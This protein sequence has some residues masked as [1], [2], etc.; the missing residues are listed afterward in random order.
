MPER[1]AMRRAYSPRGCR[2]RGHHEP[3][4]APASLAPDQLLPSRRTRACAAWMSPRYQSLVSITTATAMPRSTVNWWTTGGG[5]A[6]L[7]SGSGSDMVALDCNAGATAAAARPRAC[8]RRLARWRS[9]DSG[10]NRSPRGWRDDPDIF[11][12]ERRASSRGGNGR[13]RWTPSPRAVCSRPIRTFRT[14]CRALLSLWPR[15]RCEQLG[16]RRGARRVP[17]GVVKCSAD[18]P[19]STATGRE[20]LFHFPP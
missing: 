18:F 13:R 8:V 16:A 2:E 19:S 6:P 12:S 7:G 10:E 14:S 9:D 5:A 1:A 15:R 20:D 3:F 4:A 11:R 17:V